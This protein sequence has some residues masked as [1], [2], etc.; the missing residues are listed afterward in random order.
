[1]KMLSLIALAALA[2]CATHPSN[3]RFEQRMAVVQMMQNN[4]RAAMQT[5]YV[6]PTQP[7]PASFVCNQSGPTTYCQGQ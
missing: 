6:M 5:P 7:R 1:M 2:G 4:Q 3:L